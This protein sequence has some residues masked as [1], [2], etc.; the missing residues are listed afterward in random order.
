VEGPVRVGTNE[1]K[2]LIKAMNK[3]VEYLRSIHNPKNG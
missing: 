2:Q 1:Y 3:R